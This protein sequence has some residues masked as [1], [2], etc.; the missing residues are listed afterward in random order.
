MSEKEPSVEEI[1]SSIK[2]IVTKHD[3]DNSDTSQKGVRESKPNTIIIIAAIIFVGF[4]VVY[5]L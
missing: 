2:S 3:E 4:L 1:L 5:A